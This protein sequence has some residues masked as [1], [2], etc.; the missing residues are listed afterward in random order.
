MRVRPLLAGSVLC[1]LVG[2]AARAQSV[3]KM[4][5][6]DVGNALGDI[7]G[8]WASPFHARGRDWLQAGALV[9]GSAAISPLD[10]NIDRWAVAHHDDG[11]WSVLD[12][13]R[14]GGVLYSGKY[15]A[16]AVGGLYLVGLVT[17][18]QTVRD[19]VWGC[20][21]SYS[22]SSII[23]NTV[24]YNLV[25]RTRPDSSKLHPNGYVAPPAKSGDQY[26]FELGSTNWGRHSL[27]GGHVANIASC[28]GFLAHRFDMGYAEPVVYIVTVGVGI[29]RIVDRRHWTSDTVIG[30]VFGY[31]IG[32]EIARRSLHR[33]ERAN[34]SDSD[35]G[36]SS[37]GFYAAPV[38]DR[39]QFGWQRTF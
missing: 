36:S 4:V 31:A 39:L 2:H 12:P 33:K 27:P 1:A 19:G 28:A 21:A 17:K 25:S 6:S 5:V 30:A 23:R 15:I 20:L 37:A 13:V 7:V 22:S 11:A 29:G 8:S 38:G 32:K 34:D 26:K 18:S 3:G 10:D 35:D 9:A 24:L 14:P 16:P